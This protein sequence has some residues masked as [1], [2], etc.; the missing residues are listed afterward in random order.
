MLTVL[1]PP[2]KEDATFGDCF[3]LAIQS[4]ST[5]GYGGRCGSYRYDFDVMDASVLQR[6]IW[7]DRFRGQNNQPIKFACDH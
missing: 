3:W 6:Y 5:V 4:M 2:S 7:N 1:K